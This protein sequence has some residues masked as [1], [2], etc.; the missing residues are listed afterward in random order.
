MMLNPGMYFYENSST[1]RL[2]SGE[3]EIHTNRLNGWSATRLGWFRLIKNQWT[4]DGHESKLAES[5]KVKVDDCKGQR[6][7]ETYNNAEYYCVKNKSGIWCHQSVDA[8][9]SDQKIE[10]L[11]IN[12]VVLPNH[13]NGVDRQ[14]VVNVGNESPS[15]SVDISLDSKM[16]LKFLFHESSVQNFSG[17]MILD[18][19]SNKYFNVTYINAKGTLLGRVYTSDSKKTS[20]R[21]F[22]SEV[23]HENPNLP[24]TNFSD[25][26][27]LPPE[28][29]SS[30]YICISASGKK[31]KEI[32]NWVE[33]YPVPVEY[34]YKPTGWNPNE[35]NCPGCNEF[36]WNNFLKYLDPR[37]WFNGVTSFGEVFS[38]VL[39][40]GFYIIIIF[41]VIFVCRRCVCPFMKVV[42]CCPSPTPQKTIV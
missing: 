6:Y 23:V 42:L 9:I 21:S 10:K 28:V 26:I 33:Y 37:E 4:F 11:W 34:I 7:S 27:R 31:T 1:S 32:C 40:V 36:T 30:K 17:L 12:S 13:E 5:H 18:K 15:V 20:I 38:L 19:N 14:V 24:L 39:E 3:E 35:G 29:K 41:L 22:S 25:L 8:I 16:E 2:K